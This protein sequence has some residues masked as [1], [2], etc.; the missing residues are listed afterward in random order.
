MTDSSTLSPLTAPA[1]AS[2]I[3]LY[4]RPS[5]DFEAKLDATIELLRA[6]AEDHAG[7]IVQ[8]TSLGAEDMVV[9]DL[10]VRLGLGIAIGTLETGALH[11]ETVALIPRL[12]QHYGLKVEVYRPREE[13]VVHF[14][15]NNGA[16]AMYRSIELR[17]ACCQI[18]KMEPLAR[19]LEGR[20]A[21]VTGLRREQ[22]NNRG[23]VSFV[24]T[25]G[26]GR[27]KL[28][29][30]ADWTWNDVWHYIAQHGVPYNPLH[31]QFMPSI[32]CAPCTRAIAVGED[33]RA[34]RWWWED[35][36]AKECGLH[37]KQAETAT[38]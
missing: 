26:N 37:V 30:L 34:G 31:D 36:A 2:A 33:F 20:T 22:S 4:A 18:R 12:E 5:P 23:A 19:M 32:G 1:T 3:E 27:T 13:Q 17:K 14:V 38:A 10:L 28:N 11:P 29:P 21:W 6:V 8:A 25:D 24:E 16:E 9:T 15:R 7:H 35:E